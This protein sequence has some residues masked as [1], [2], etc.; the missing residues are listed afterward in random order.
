MRMDPTPDAHQATSPRPAEA[1]GVLTIDLAA[2]VANW[3]TLAARAAPAECAAVVKADAYGCGIESVAT[4]LCRAGCRTFFVAQLP[5]ARRARA[6]LP[7]STIY[8][9]GGLHPGAASTY[10]S[11]GLR[12]V[13]SSSDE[14]REWTGFTASGGTAEAALHIDTG[15]NRLGVSLDEAAAWASDKD[16]QR[17][18]VSLLL[19]HLAVADDPGHP[20]NARQIG[21]FRELRDFFP[22]IPGSLANSSGIFLG[23]DA[24]HDM[25]RPGAALYGVNPTPTHSNPMQPVVRLEGRVLQVREVEAGEAVGYGA[26][27]IAP[28]PTRLAIISIGY[29]DGFPRSAGATDFKPGA[30]VLVAGRPCPLAGR[31]SMDLLA[32]DV[33][34]VPEALP[35]RGDFVTV[36]GDAIGVDELASHAGTIGY[37]ILT[38]LG[39]RYYRNYVGA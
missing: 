31:V 15:M 12:P 8:V 18:N 19:S 22:G 10:E 5:E 9:L 1:D 35:R 33:T 13:L 2:I 17:C 14:L 4:A 32:V 34:D 16:L 26:T 23:P 30:D 28:R 20:L 24:H 7:H 27:W 29:A 39:R 6:C 36:L 21:L 38:R 25:V 37:E 11:L 3:R